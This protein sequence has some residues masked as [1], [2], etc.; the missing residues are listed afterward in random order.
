MKTGFLRMNYKD[1]IQL[2]YKI[3]NRPAPFPCVGDK[4]MI[5]H[6][7]RRTVEKVLM[8]QGVLVT[9]VNVSGCQYLKNI[10]DLWV[11]VNLDYIHE[12]YAK[13][14]YDVFGPE[15]SED[16]RYTNRPIPSILDL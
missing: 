1:W 16:E 8:T 2:E 11:I 12:N 14:Y 7:V 3:N 9:G 15:S 13:L 10:E 6:K 5:T 4:V